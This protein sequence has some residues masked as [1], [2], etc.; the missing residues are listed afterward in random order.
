M[1]CERM[2]LN[3]YPSNEIQIIFLK[4]ISKQR[5]PNNILC[6]SHLGATLVDSLDTFYIAGLHEEFN[7]AR[8]WVRHIEQVMDNLCRF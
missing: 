4:P 7:V 6:N 2:N 8:K 1:K 3:Q 5:N